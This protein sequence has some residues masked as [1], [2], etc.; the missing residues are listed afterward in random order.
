MAAHILA[1]LVQSVIDALCSLVG[2]RS[3]TITVLYWLANRGEW[4]QLVRHSVEEILKLTVRDKSKFSPGVDNT[5][6][7]G[8]RNT[9][10]SELKTCG[11]WWSGPEWLSEPSE[12]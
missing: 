11:M 3:D 9:L 1:R 2:E 5:A 12:G 6:N 10:A 7:V 8:S 4:K